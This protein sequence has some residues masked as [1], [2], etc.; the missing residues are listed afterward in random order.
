MAQYIIHD[1]QDP[2][3]IEAVE[4][5]CYLVGYVQWTAPTE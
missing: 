1:G 2:E 5:Q 4:Q 3:T